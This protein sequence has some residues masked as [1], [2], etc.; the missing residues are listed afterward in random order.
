M[1]IK[2]RCKTTTAVNNNSTITSVNTYICDF[3]N[4]IQS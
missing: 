4:I 2:T 3:K 1:Q